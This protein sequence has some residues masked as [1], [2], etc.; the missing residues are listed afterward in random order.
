MAALLMGFVLALFQ[1]LTPEFAT[2]AAIS[3]GAFAAAN[4]YSKGKSDPGTS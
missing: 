1:R 2:I 3:V 4:A